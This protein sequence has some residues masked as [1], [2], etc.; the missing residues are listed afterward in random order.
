MAAVLPSTPPALAADRVRAERVTAD[1]VPSGR[2]RITHP[3]LWSGARALAARD[4][5]LAW[6][7]RTDTLA[8]LVF[9]LMVSSLFPLA[10]GP[11]PQ[12]LQ[13]MAGG[14]VWVSALL[15]GML[16][17]ARL[18]NDD[19]ADGTLEQLLLSPHP[20]PLLVLGKVLAH[21][22]GSGLLVTLAAPLIAVQYG[23]SAGA[24]GV[25]VLTL[26][27]GT[28]ILSLLG[29]V[30]AAL[31]VGLRGGAML[32]ALLVLPLCV[33]VLVFGA[34]AVQAHEA[35]LG[36]AAHLSLLGAGLLLS[37]AGAPVACALA[38]RISLEA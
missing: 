27:L 36:V 25:L 16:S 17:L 14:V 8:A 22:L 10:V 26:L 6:R 31:T 24:I 21:W 28:P 3:G 12:T 32:L 15:A 20:L 9:F 29:A 34:G 33:P 7:R 35:G 2:P 4:L 5:R 37:L 1:L 13:R 11:E 19:L 38:L 23:L 30:T 18:F